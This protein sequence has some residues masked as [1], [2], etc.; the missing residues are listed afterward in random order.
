MPDSQTAMPTF[1]RSSRCEAVNCAEVALVGDTTALMR[2]STR[3][4]THLAFDAVTWRSF[5]A[6]VAAGEFDLPRA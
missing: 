4:D 2:N 3:P 1:R 5:I 6:G